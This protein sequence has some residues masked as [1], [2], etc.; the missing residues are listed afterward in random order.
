MITLSDRELASLKAELLRICTES[1]KPVQRQHK[2]YNIAQKASLI[3]KKAERRQ[4]DTLNL[5]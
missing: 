1:R 2:I 3:I 5:F 4:R